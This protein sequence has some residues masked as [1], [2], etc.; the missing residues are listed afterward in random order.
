MKKIINSIYKYLQEISL[1]FESLTNKQKIWAFVCFFIFG[2]I[3]LPNLLVYAVLFFA[4]AR[5]MN[6]G[7]F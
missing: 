5:F 3:I 6:K 4:L 7:F 2:T 1:K